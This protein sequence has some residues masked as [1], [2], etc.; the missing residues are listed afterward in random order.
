MNSDEFE[1]QLRR[2]PLRTVPQEWR[3]DILQTT[4]AVSSPQSST[5]NPQ[6]TSSWRDL[7]LPLRWHL[8]GIGAAWIIIALLNSPQSSA[9]APATA[10]RDIPS[11]QQFVM[12]LRENRRQL[13]E[14]I[15][16]A[17]A[18]TAPAPPSRVSPRRSEIESSTAVV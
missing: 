8:A 11:S 13:L 12:T 9:P 16:P 7:L 5:L 14:L 4:R 18:E 10:K 2:Q 6:R 15:N 1:K 17:I 3:S